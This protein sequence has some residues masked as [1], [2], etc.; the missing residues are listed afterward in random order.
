MGPGDDRGDERRLVRRMVAGDEQAFELFA[1]EY[2]PPLYRFAC[3]RL[4]GDT[5]LARE[6]V[7]A[8]VVKAIA[9]LTGFRG[10]AGLSTWLC[11]CCR[12]EIAAHFRGATRAGLAVGIDRLEEGAAHPPDPPPPGPEALLLQRERGERVHE[13]LDTLPP[14]Y[15][16]ALEWKYLQD[17]PVLEIAGRLNLGAKAAESL[18]TR[19]RLAFRTAYESLSAPPADPA[20]A[21]SRGAAPPGRRLEWRS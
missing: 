17:L 14:R 9:N 8:T 20:G 15:G 7:Q 11:A 2:L 4:R 13:A 5:E 1:D 10:E 19:A 16:R 12:N 21:A 18:L 3:R 6:V